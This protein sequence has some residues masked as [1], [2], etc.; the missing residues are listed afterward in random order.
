MSELLAAKM[1]KWLNGDI[2]N[3]ELVDTIEETFDSFDNKDEEACSHRIS[4]IQYSLIRQMIRKWYEHQPEIPET[5]D[6][7]SIECLGRI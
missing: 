2:T 3:S 6:S 1:V 5:A 7:Y 4:A